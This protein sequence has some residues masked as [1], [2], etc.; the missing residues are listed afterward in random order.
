MQRQTTTGKTANQVQNWHLIDA[1]G[2]T[3]GRMATRVATLIRGKHK[4][5]F[6]P[7]ID[8]GDQVVIINAD[9]VVL[10]GDK[11]EGK[12]YYNH[13]GHP[14]G[15]RVRTAQTMI[16][17]YPEEM[18]REAVRGMVPHTKLG[19]QQIKHLHVYKGSEHLHQ[20]Q[21]PVPFEIK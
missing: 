21:N 17:R 15:L 6:S 7:N 11:L 10:T 13:S 19:R 16:E 18:V 9:K 2:L 4:V 8:G 3:L 20:A 5:D 14:G 12:K 1:S